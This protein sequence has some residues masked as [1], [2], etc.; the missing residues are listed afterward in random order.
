M[1]AGEPPLPAG[2]CCGLGVLESGRFTMKRARIALLA[3]LAAGALHASPGRADVVTLSDGSRLLGTVERMEAGKLILATKFAGTLEIDAALVVTISTDEAV[4]VGMDTGDQ[5]VGP[6]E[7]KPELDRAVVETEFGGIPVSVERIEAIWP[8]DGKSPEVLAMEEQVAKIREEMEARAAKWSATFEAGLVFQEGNTD[9]FTV[10]GRGELVR[11]SPKDLLKFYL[12]GEYAEQDDQRNA[13][14][15]KGGAYYEH[16]ISERWFVYGRSDLE[17]DEFESLD[18]RFSTAAGPGFYWL[19]EPDHELKTRGG[20]GYLH[21]TYMD[22]RT[23]DA[24]QAEFGLDYRI[25]VTPWL[26]FMHGTTYYPT[27]DSLRDYRLV[28]D[29]AFVFPLGDSDKWKFKLGAQYEYKSLPAPGRERLD[30]TY[31][32]NVVLELK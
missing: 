14:E 17:Y 19:K 6:I 28:S 11:T 2:C 24:A 31:Y 16:M 3:L 1:P 13:H 26:Q 5:L 30:Q 27:F 18:F 20:L 25:D 4:H 8:K 12:S 9:I 21:E 23:N 7:W 29:S 22:G 10:R 15:V 32:G